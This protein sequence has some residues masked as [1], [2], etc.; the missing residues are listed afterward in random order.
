MHDTQQLIKIID[1]WKK[2]VYETDLIFRPIIDKIDYK[3]RE[4]VDIIGPRR[5]GKSSILKLLIKKLELSNFLFIN[6]EDPYFVTH[7]EPQVVEELIDVYKEY[8]S[9]NLKYLFFD[10][11]HAINHWENAIRK[12]RDSGKY[13]IFVTGS[14]SKLLGKELSTLLTGRHLSYEILPLSFSEFLS[15]KS[16]ELKNKRDIVIREKSFLKN[17]DEYLSIG[18]FPEIVNTGNLALL[19]QYYFDIIQKDIVMRYDVRQKDILE[20]MG[21]YL[22]TNLAKSVS[23][24]SLKNTFN[25][26]FEAASG[27]LD[28]FEEAFLIYEV[29]QF[30]YSLKTQQQAQ[31]K[32][33][34]IDSGLANTI[35]FRFSKESGRLLEQ[36]VFLELKRKGHGIYYYKTENNKEVDFLVQQQNR[37]KNLIQV[38]WDISDEDTKKRELNSLTQAMNELKLTNGL[39]LTYNNE[40][41]LQ[42][43]NRRITV[44]P[45]YKWMID[46]SLFV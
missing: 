27:Y 17:F 7:N 35:S 18:G 31:K 45:V 3:S 43:E 40:Q 5:S 6:F 39:I 12:L 2:T 22:I 36:C 11:I 30:S 13:K 23:I 41:K 33:Y 34:S 10:E 14:S 25:L 8:F 21:I 32:I 38:C 29:P 26:S 19:K 20:K 37:K 46:K 15:F 9:R 42:V 1:F 4:I 24:E 44:M 28:Y 16:V